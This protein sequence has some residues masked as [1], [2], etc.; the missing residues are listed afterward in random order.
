MFIQKRKFPCKVVQKKFRMSK[1][2]FFISTFLYNFDIVYKY[3]WPVFFLADLRKETFV[4]RELSICIHQ[5]IIFFRKYFNCQSNRFERRYCK[6]ITFT[7][8]RIIL[9]FY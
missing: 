3:T 2:I 5:F 6:K 1:F 4:V 9:L 8:S 7:P